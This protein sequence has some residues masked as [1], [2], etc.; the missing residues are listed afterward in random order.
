[1][2][3]SKVGIVT[4]WSKVLQDPAFAP[5]S[6]T[7]VQGMVCRREYH[8]LYGDGC[9]GMPEKPKSNVQIRGAI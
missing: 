6:L 5:K 4:D 8:D 2:G 7:A 3:R 1:M 9:E